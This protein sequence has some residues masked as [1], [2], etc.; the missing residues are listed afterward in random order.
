MLPPRC[1]CRNENKTS[2]AAIILHAAALQQSRRCSNNAAAALLLF[3]CRCDAFA[4]PLLFCRYRRDATSP[5]PPQFSR[6]RNILL[7]QPPLCRNYASTAAMP[8]SRCRCDVISSPQPLFSLP[9]N[10]PAP[11]TW[12]H[13]INIAARKPASPKNVVPRESTPLVSLIH[14]AAGSPPA[15]SAYARRTSR[16]QYGQN[17]QNGQ[18]GHE[19]AADTKIRLP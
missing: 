14:F 11:G 2:A 4:S 17:G 18:N 5:P 1:C 10:L 16:Y 7:P 13:P 19:V 9:E 15:L 8:Q 12:Y 3:R 6:W